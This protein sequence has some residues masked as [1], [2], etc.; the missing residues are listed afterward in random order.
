[1]IGIILRVDASFDI[2]C[3]WNYLFWNV[4][5]FSFQA[6][7][8]CET[9]CRSC[10]PATLKTTTG[11]R[12]TPSPLSWPPSTKSSRSRRSFPGMRTHHI[13][14]QRIIFKCHSPDYE[15]DNIT[16]IIESLW[17]WNL[18]WDIMS[19]S[20]DRCWRRVESTGWW[21]SL[22]NANGSRRGS[23]SLPA[24][25]STPCGVT[26]YRSYTL[27]PGFIFVRTFCDVMNIHE[28]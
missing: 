11:R 16:R 12:T 2:D 18:N 13:N 6:N 23:S 28:N 22:T 25:S 3:I 26:R 17:S 27:H 10:R 7:M 8:Q 5:F 9:W 21:Q 24:R 20:I 14:P 1:M 15:T 19:P 4:W